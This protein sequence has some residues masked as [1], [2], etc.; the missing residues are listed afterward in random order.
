VFVLDCSVTMAWLFDDEDDLRA[1]A[2]RDSLDA[3]MALVPAIWPLEVANALVVAERRQR[4]SRAEA[5]RFLEVLRQLPI[6]VGAVP[7][8]AAVEGAL[9]IAH[10]TGLSVYDAAYLDL[11][12]TQGLPLA[13]L[14]RRLA[15]AAARVGVALCACE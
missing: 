6:D 4:V 14:D 11:A 12:A 3:D 2:V 9:Q 15:A 8:L 13:T 10:E 1:A 7:S 5:L